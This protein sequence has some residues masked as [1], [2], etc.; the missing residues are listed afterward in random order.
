M[1][2]IKNFLKGVEM[3]NRNSDYQGWGIA[4]LVFLGLAYM[5]FTF[6]TP[7]EVD[8]EWMSEQYGHLEKGANNAR[9]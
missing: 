5:F 4:I 8:R 3:S 1:I 2:L 7:G 9:K 6:K